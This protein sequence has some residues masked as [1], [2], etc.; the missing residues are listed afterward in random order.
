MVH[1]AM[2]QLTLQ[3]REVLL[4]RFLEDM[5]CDEIAAVTG[6][7]E[8]TVKSRLHYAKHSLRRI[9]EEMDDG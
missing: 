6:C 9:M 8:G 2:A 3:H 7:K 5:S 4:L 1:V